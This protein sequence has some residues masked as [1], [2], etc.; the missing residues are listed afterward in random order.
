MSG[1]AARSTFSASAVTS[2]P[3]PSPPITASLTVDP[4]SEPYWCW[5]SVL[6]A[7]PAHQRAEPGADLLDLLGPLG[8]APLEEVRLAGVELLDEL[9]GEGAVLDLAEDLAHLLAGPLVDQARATGV[10]AVFCGVRDGPVHLGD[11][12]LVHEVHDQLHLVQALEVRGLRLVSGLDKRR[13]TGLDQL[14]DATAEHRLLAEHVGLGL[15]L[16]GGPEHA[17]AGAA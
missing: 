14:R 3:M 13:E 7:Q 2:G 11:A 12:A 16:E 5:P 4:M 10:P 6:V 1:A 9:A 17:G 15:F 8:F